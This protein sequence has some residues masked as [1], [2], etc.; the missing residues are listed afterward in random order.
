MT[1][2]SRTP[3][4]QHALD[5]RADQCRL[6][7]DLKLEAIA[8]YESDGFAWSW[9][10]RHVG[11][12]ARGWSMI[13][14][15]KNLDEDEEEGNGQKVVVEIFIF[16]FSYCIFYFVREWVRACTDY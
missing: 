16:R 7:Q 1:S 15:S 11:A 8:R 3:H 5:N 10:H 4:V 14:A 6:A 13:R 9:R 12:K 2:F